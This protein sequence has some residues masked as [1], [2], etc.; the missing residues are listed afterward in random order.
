MTLAGY[1]DETA[2]SSNVLWMDHH[3]MFSFTYPH[4]QAEHQPGKLVRVLE[5][6][7]MCA[8]TSSYQR[9]L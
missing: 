8:L 7:Y 3:C 1:H 5:L 6:L 9:I 4:H 2:P